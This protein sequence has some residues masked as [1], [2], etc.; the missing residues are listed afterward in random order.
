M[1]NDR[2]SACR[3]PTDYEK[4]LASD[5]DAVMI[6]MPAFLHAEHFEKAV[7]AGKH[8]YIE[9]PA[10]PGCSRPVPRHNRGLRGSDQRLASTITRKNLG[11]EVKPRQ[12][13]PT[14]RSRSG[15]AQLAWRHNLRPVIRA[16]ALGAPRYASSLSRMPFTEDVLGA[17]P[18][19]AAAQ[20]AYVLRWG[21]G[22]GT[23]G[24]GRIPWLRR[25]GFTPVEPSP[26]CHVGAPCDSR[27]RRPV[28]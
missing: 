16:L 18:E 5:V 10:A 1:A 9:K 17:G 7:Q 14:Q 4:L 24:I 28:A 26:S 8:I 21:S 25:F 20:G 11:P 6:S 12:R 15:R 13:C 23:K 22:A 2:G 19:G 3:G 27:D